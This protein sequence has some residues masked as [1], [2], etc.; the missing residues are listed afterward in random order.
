MG[1]PVGAGA[2][3]LPENSHSIIREEA[4]W[5]SDDDECDGGGARADGRTPWRGH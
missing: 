4:R 2:T 3:R 5:V 1:A